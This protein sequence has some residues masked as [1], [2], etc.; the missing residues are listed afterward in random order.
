MRPARRPAGR[1]LEPW[2][3]AVR[4]GR[5][6]VTWKYA[7]T[8][9]GRT[10]AADGTSRWITGPQARAQVHQLRAD[11]DAVIVGVG[12]VL[13]DDPRLTVR[14]ADGTPTRRQPL[15]VVF[16]RTGR[17]PAGAKVR[18]DAAPTLL[19]TDSPAGVL[20][21]LYQRGA[22]SALLEGG[23]TLA[24]AFVAAGLIDRVV[25]YLAPRLLGA[26][27]P[28]LAGAGIATLTAA[29]GLR[30]DTVA[31]IGSDVRIVARPDREE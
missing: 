17:T 26:G 30:I 4:H 8:L 23:A 3:F 16:D 22:R 9:D 5:A 20:A 6:F 10:A 24:G 25:G 29:A 1:A 19:T 15:R 14:D 18:D 21:T 31:Q 27:P 28:V 13:A 7:A 12:T 2:L 11:S